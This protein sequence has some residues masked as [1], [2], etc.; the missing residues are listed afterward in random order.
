MVRGGVPVPDA[1]PAAPR[2]R[3]LAGSDP[4]RERKRHVRRLVCDA[5]RTP[6]GKYRGA[7]LHGT[8]PVDLVVGLI[9][10]VQEGN[11]TPLAPDRIWES[12]GAYGERFLP[13]ASLVERAERGEIYE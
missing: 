2:T 8:K 5:V 1:L 13:P 9:H 11:P 6:R 12:A 3:L 10:A 7:A 4:S